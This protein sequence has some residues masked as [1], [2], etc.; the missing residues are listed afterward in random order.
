[1]KNSDEVIFDN[2]SFQVVTNK[3]RGCYDVI[4]KSTGIIEETSN[5]QFQAMHYAVFSK[6]MIK[7]LIARQDDATWGE[8]LAEALEKKPH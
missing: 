2:G 5:G 7:D 3:G 1:M 6:N 4:N 8:S